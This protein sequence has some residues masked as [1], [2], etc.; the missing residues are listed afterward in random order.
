MDVLLNW[1]E[2]NAWA[3]YALLF[4]Y[5]AFKSGALPLFA[6]IVAQQGALDVWVVAAAAFLGGYLGD[7]ARF[8]IARR[9][10]DGLFQSR[11]RARAWLDRATMAMERYGAAYIFLYHYPKGMRTIGALPVGLSTMPWGRFTALN[12]AS[13]ALWSG[14]LVGVGYLLGDQIV[15][16]AE[17]WWGTASVVLLIGF[18]VISWLVLRRIGSNALA[19]NPMDANPAR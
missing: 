4:G 8:A 15:V 2:M 10:G 11:P 14:V 1:I 19:P 12:A 7:E 5:C 13:A 3:V 17:S 9:W 16:A 18:L 6:G